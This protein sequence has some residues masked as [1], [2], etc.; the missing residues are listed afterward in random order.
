V[1]MEDEILPTEDEVVEEQPK[2]MEDTITETL[3]AINAR[4]SEPQPEP[5]LEAE[6]AEE[7]AERLRDE[8]GR[9]AKKDEPPAEITETPLEPQAQAPAV[10]PPELQKLGLRKEEAEALANNPVALNAF[11]RRAEEQ[12]QGFERIRPHVELGQQME[13]AMSP[14][15]QTIQQTGLPPAEAV[16]RVL[17]AE[18]GFRYGNDDQRAVHAL[19]VLQSYNIDL[20]RLFSI[21][22][23]Q[24]QPQVQPLQV[25][26]A[27]QPDP[28]DLVRQELD[29]YFLQQEIA[30]SA[31]GKE[32]FDELRPLMA[33][34]L[35]NGAA[36]TLDEAYTQAL[37][38][39][40]TYGKEM[41]AKQLADAEEKR[42]SE[43]KAKAMQARQ[44]A[45]V[46]LPRK[47]ANAP[48][49][50]VGS[51]EDTIRAAAQSLGIDAR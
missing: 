14:F 15:M 26:Q 23:G 30:R 27:P 43:A 49:R 28:R 25:P 13:Q 12:R 33:S 40:P 39:H 20:N 29:G 3:A 6:T 8:K 38:A 36:Q 9:F 1:K 45:S 22:S 24:H 19:N 4:E 32:H 21:A 31:Q 48:A 11:M 47:G 50:A 42:R 10:V 51:M 41:V 7:K 44:A 34:L 46:N 17:A 37:M 16:G 18:H 35:E 2:T 5:D